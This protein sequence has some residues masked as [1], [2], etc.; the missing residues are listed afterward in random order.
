MIDKLPTITFLSFD[1]QNEQKLDF[2]VS[3]NVIFINYN[4]RVEKLPAKL[5][6]ICS[7]R[8]NSL[9]LNLGCFDYTRKIFEAPTMPAPFLDG[10]RSL[11]YGANLTIGLFSVLL[12]VLMSADLR[13][14]FFQGL[15][16]RFVPF[17]T[18]IV[19]LCL[20][21]T[22]PD[23]QPHYLFETCSTGI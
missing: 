11:N 10:K 6:S 21:T 16:P 8:V 5:T 14:Q 23:L 15:F 4:L 3:V 9:E 2:T 20:Q 12:R 17:C 1:E 22:K 18:E 19:L 7:L 13:T